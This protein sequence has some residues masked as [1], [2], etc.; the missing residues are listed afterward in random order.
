MA[1]IPPPEEISANFEKFQI[2]RDD[3]LQDMRNFLNEHKEIMAGQY[4]DFEM[5]KRRFEE[6]NMKMEGEKQKVV[7]ER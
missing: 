4:E 1:A 3:E 7:N 5:E 6:M 2:L